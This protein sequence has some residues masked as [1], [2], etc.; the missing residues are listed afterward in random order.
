MPT[1]DVRGRG[2]TIRFA[3][4]D[5]WLTIEFDGRGSFH[6]ERMERIDG[7]CAVDILAAPSPEARQ[8]F[9]I[10]VKDFRTSPEAMRAEAAGGKLWQ[11]LVR[12]AIHSI[13][14]AY[15][16]ASVGYR[17]VPPGSAERDGDLL[18]FGAVFQ[19][20]PQRIEFVFWLEQDQPMAASGSSEEKDEQENRRKMRQNLE[21]KIKGKLER[22]G[23]SVRLA[24]MATWGPAEPWRV[25]A[26]P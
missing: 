8:L 1:I 5:D 26:V 15:L 4:P 9:L 13:G 19:V 21:V 12:K 22:L 20:P 10:E 24:E 2:G 11:E 7:Q 16:G 25:T 6:R 18:H 17:I 23:I 3:F 14:T